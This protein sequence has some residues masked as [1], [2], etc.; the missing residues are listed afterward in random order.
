M[1]KNTFLRRSG[2]VL[3]TAGVTAALTLGLPLAAN[4]AVQA[5]FAAQGSASADYNGPTIGGTCLLSDGDDGAESSIAEFTHGTKHRSANLDATFASSDNAADTVRVRG[6]VAADFTVRKKHRDLMAFEL[7]VGGS[8]KVTHALG[9]SAC[10]G[11]GFVAGAFILEFTEHHKGYLYVTRDTRKEGSI[12]EFV[13]INLKNGKLVTLDIYTGG[14]SHEV[15]RALLKPGKYAVE[16]AEA[17]LTTGTSGIIL[18][19]GAPVSAKIARSIHLSGEF[20]R[21]H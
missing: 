11:S 2:V 12:A 21:T 9:G 1:K 4:A 15:S 17:G 3:T 5:Q 10:D 13:L 8:V 16:I 7:A 14:K 18:K 19:S 20:K 6:H